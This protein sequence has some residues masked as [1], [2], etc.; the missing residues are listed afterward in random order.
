MSTNTPTLRDR[1]ADALMHWADQFNSPAYAS[2]RRPQMDVEN[3]YRRADAVL[4]VLPAPV[5]RGT[6]LREAAD[7][8]ESLRQFEPAFGARK[9]AQV[10]ENVGILRVADELRRR[11]EKAPAAP[12]AQHPA[13]PV[14]G[15]VCGGCTQYPADMRPAPA[16]GQRYTADTITGAALDALYAELRQTQ[17]AIERARALASRWGVLRAYGGAATE[18]RTALDSTA[19]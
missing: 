13:V 18:L 17:A 3:S 19:Q 4:A 11:A 10:S 12:C 1:I 6:V 5:D 2:M 8:A 7:I 15:G 14:I 9:S 16:A